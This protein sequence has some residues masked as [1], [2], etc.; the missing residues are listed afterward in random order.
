MSI[1]VSLREFFRRALRCARGFASAR[2]GNVAMIFALSLIPLAIAA[3]VGLD[4][5]RAVMVRASLAQ[6]ID[7]AALAIG[8]T[9]GLSTTQMQTLAQQY[10][11]ANYKADSS[12]GTP[13]ALSVTP[14]S[15]TQ[16]LTISVSDDVPTILLSAAG[17][18]TL[19]VNVFTTVVWGQ[20][21]VWV[22]LVLDNTGSMTE[23]DS[24]GT[25]K[26]SALQS[27]SH[28]LLTMLQNASSN[29]G[30]VQVAI[31]PFA[32]D[33]NLGKSYSASS[34]LGWTDFTAA[35]TTPSTSVGPGSSCPWTDSNN[36]FHCQTTPTNG[37]SSTSKV[38]SSGTYKGYICPSLNR[39]GHYYN[40]CFNSV[41]SSGHYNHTWIANATSTW[42]GCI[43]DRTQDYDTLNTTPTTGTP[44]TLFI[45]DNTPNCPVA[46]LMPL[47][48]DWT[49]LSNK[50][51]SMVAN[52]NTNQTIG[53]AWGWQALTQGAP[54]SPPAL[55]ANTQQYII[56]FSDGL[57]TENRW[58]TTQSSI[59]AREQLACS[60]AKAA[61]IV[62][63]TVYVDLNGT[64]GNSAVL[65]SCA[66][67]AS[68]YFDLT[69]SGQIVSTFNQIG[70]QITNL[71]VSQ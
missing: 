57:N 50:I 32:R 53:L 1:G 39:V 31:V 18:N 56:L 40:G 25:S 15:A 6:A 5:A 12:Y 11:S 61:G 44:A 35:P 3:G 23:T 27:A 17:I 43:T 13:S 38:P 29:P 49:A 30:D 45:P 28:Q 63:Y 68:K 33:V 42:S 8:A 7:S 71:H 65:Q 51:N 26:L 64:Q 36:G 14:S 24:T 19:A 16:S 66:S 54:L 70:Q 41:S 58:T 59:D 10:F 46:T 22:A 67:D 48:Y 55:P 47:S 2:R 37:S 60:N 4:Y 20:A 34:W 21:K 69:T 9:P 62:I 52:G